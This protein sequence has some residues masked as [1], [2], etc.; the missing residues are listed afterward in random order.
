MPLDTR[1]SSH[2]CERTLKRHTQN[3]MTWM[4]AAW[5]PVAAVTYDN[6][7]PGVS[8]VDSRVRDPATS[9]ERR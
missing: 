9:T 1:L 3:V 8:G 5:W 7:R 4:A 2:Q 6:E